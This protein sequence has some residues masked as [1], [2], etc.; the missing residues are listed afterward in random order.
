MEKDLEREHGVH[1][2]SLPPH[3]NHRAFG[4][5]SEISSKIFINGKTCTAYFADETRWEA[6]Y[7]NGRKWKRHTTKTDN[8]LS[9]PNDWHSFHSNRKR[10]EVNL[11]SLF[12]RSFI[13]ICGEVPPPRIYL[14]MKFV[15]P[16][17]N[18]IIT[19]LNISM[20]WRNTL[21]MPKIIHFFLYSGRKV[22]ECYGT[23]FH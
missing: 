14:C 18:L 12:R 13:R 19:S 8:D 2:L 11:W 17:S 22:F 1:I 6:L 21:Y 16:K 3:C 15:F 9:W 4:K 7:S 5:I 23:Q 20:W 10:W